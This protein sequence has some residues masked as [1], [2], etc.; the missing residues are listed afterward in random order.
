MAIR[1]FVEKRPGFRVE[2]E[3]LLAELNSNLSLNLAGLRLVNVYDLD[4]FSRELL[5]KCRYSVFGETVKN[6]VT[7]SFPLEGKRFLCV[8]YLPSQYDQRA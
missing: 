1:I 3:S 2:A 7:D 5:E 6:T 8:E 4:G